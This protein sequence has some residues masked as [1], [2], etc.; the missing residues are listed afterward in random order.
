MAHAH[1][2]HK[3]VRNETISVR[4]MRRTL[5]A[6]WAEG[7]DEA[8]AEVLSSYDSIFGVVI[9]MMLSSSRTIRYGSR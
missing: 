6:L 1:Q 2:H 5:M 9:I 3:V 8:A 7:Q 4:D